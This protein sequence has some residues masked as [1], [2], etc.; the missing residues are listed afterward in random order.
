MI[1][2]LGTTLLVTASTT[3]VLLVVVGLLLRR[4]IQRIVAQLTDIQATI[5][6]L[7][8]ELQ[9]TT[10]AMN[11]EFERVAERAESINRG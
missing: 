4:R 3:V 6:P 2:V 1:S 11:A 7:V 10:T 8:E 9:A 5:M